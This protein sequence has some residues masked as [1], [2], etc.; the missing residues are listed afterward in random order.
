MAAT[1]KGA[2]LALEGAMIQ[3]A[4]AIATAN[5]VETNLDM[6]PPRIVASHMVI[7]ALALTAKGGH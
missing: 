2:V 3:V 4:T 6:L 5:A 7:Q 1:F